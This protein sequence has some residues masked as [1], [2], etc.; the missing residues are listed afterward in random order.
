VIS[1]NKETSGGIHMGSRLCHEIVP[2]FNEYP[3]KAHSLERTADQK[4][5]RFETAVRAAVGLAKI[6]QAHN[7][8]A[9][10]RFRDVH[11]RSEPAVFVPSL[12]PVTAPHLFPFAVIEGVSPDR[13]G[14]V[15]FKP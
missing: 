11:I 2:P 8:S 13:S 4:Q 1:N 12:P 3:Y 9:T 5:Q 15:T 14:G 7:R 6:E 10:P